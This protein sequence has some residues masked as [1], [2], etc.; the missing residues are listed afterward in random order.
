[1]RRAVVLGL[2]GVLAI[3]AGCTGKGSERGPGDPALPTPGAGSPSASASASARAGAPPGVKPQRAAPTVVAPKGPVPCEPVSVAM[4]LTNLRR[5]AST[6]SLDIL[7]TN[8]SS[9]TCTVSGHARVAL[10]SDDGSEL[11]TTFVPATSP[12]PV[13]V[14]VAPRGQARMT[15]RWST[16]PAPDEPADGPCTIPATVVSV[17]LTEQPPPLDLYAKSRTMPDGIG[18]VC[19]HGRLTG[20]AWQPA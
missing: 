7:L 12:K 15:V 16:R 6:A 18:P 20:T 4:Q 2:L 9:R 8:A 13:V 19:D 3:L 11:P 5:A 17:F 1:M 10:S 14:T